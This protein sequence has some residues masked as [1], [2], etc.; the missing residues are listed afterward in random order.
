MELYHLGQKRESTIQHLERDVAVY[1]QRL[2]HF[3]NLLRPSASYPTDE[4]MQLVKE[5]CRTPR[6]AHNNHNLAVLQYHEIIQIDAQLTRLSEALGQDTRSRAPLVGLMVL[7]RDISN[8][9]S[10]RQTRLDADVIAF[11]EKV[12]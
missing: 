8:T 3:R 10:E 9:I 5:A 2:Q 4:V 11:Q 7:F 6:P 1:H 12:C